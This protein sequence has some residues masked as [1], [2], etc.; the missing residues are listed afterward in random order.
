MNEFAEKFSNL[1]NFLIRN[2]KEIAQ[3]EFEYLG[4]SFLDSVTVEEQFILEFP[5]SRG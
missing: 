5:D 1:Y 2:K 3:G 4:D